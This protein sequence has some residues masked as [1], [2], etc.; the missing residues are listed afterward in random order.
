VKHRLRF[1][2]IP[3]PDHKQSWRTQAVSAA[4]RCGHSAVTF[5]QPA[6]GG[7]IRPGQS[8]SVQ[9][10]YAPTAPGPATGSFTI[11]GSSGRR[12]TVTLTGTGTAAVSRLAAVRPGH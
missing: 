8:I 3:S 6:V 11:A 9:V 5:T 1:A 12:A 10:S 2:I 7:N 4:P